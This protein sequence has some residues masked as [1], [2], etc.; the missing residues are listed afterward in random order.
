M[1]PIIRYASLLSIAFVAASLA[2]NDLHAQGGG[3]GGGAGAGAG[4]AGGA[5]ARGGRGNVQL[6]ADVLTLRGPRPVAD[7][8]SFDIAIGLQNDSRLQAALAEVSA[9]RLRRIDS[10]LV[11][12][13]SRTTQSDTLS[14]TRGIGAARRW[15]FSELQS[16]SRDCN[17]C[18]KVEYHQQMNTAQRMGNNPV[19]L[20]NVLGILPGR[21]T[22][23]VMVLGGHYDSCHCSGGTNPLTDEAPGANDDGSGSSA[24][25]EL[26]RVM[27]K[28]YPGGLEVSVIFAL[29]AGEENGLIG[30][31]NLARK[32]TAEGKT[33][34]AAVTNDIVGNVE[35]DDGRKDST[36]V[37]VFSPGSDWGSYSDNGPSRELGRYV[38]ALSKVYL[39]NDPSGDRA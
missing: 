21:D 35:S 33:I 14:D 38:W 24:M 18:L 39:P 15:I 29:Y 1:N 10:M 19:N 9:D 5:A 17:G 20:V 13:G 6:P 4:A 11:S 22:T 25:I 26:A 31:T 3:R 27:S 36:T 23:R 8:F 30:S 16:Y 2:A 12:F 34:I 37:R 28:N 32:L 7:D